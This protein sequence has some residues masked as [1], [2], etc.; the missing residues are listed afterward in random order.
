MVLAV[1]AMSGCGSKKSAASRTVLQTLDAVLQPTA[2]A[3][4]LVSLGGAH[5]HATTLFHV[6]TLARDPA[7]DGT[8]PA[9]PAAITTTTDLWLD[10]HG[11]FRLLETNDQDG[12]REVV[13]VGQEVAVA[14]RYGKMVRRAAQDAESSRFL[15]E[16][17]GAPWALWEVV[18]RQVEVE[19]GTAGSYH[20]SLSRRA[21]AWP[22]GFPPA[23]GL[24][25]WRESAEVKALE[26]Q[27]TVGPDGRTLIAF[28]C[29]AT[30]QAIRDEVPIEGDMTVSSSLDQVGSAEDV[31]MP[32]VDSL[33]PRQRTVLEERALLGGLGAAISSA[34]K[35][36]AR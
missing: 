19:S 21:V 29:K 35:K 25:K 27:V 4:A 13:R 32:S 23:V 9:S 30:F 1:A 7:G 10:K 11:N 15:V 8:A 6:E 3:A 16:A 34:G 31:V 33:H 20:V 12:G 17:L 5:V 28:T 14:L 18:R 22:P 2:Q 36:G 26:G 24:R